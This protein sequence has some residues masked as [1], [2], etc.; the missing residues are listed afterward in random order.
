M[1]Y[2]LKA[3]LPDATLRVLR[4]CMHS[5]Q[6]EHPAACGA[7]IREFLENA[8]ERAPEIAEVDPRGDAGMELAARGLPTH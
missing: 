2:R 1:G 6:L 4:Y 3:Q 8:D 7:L 5:P